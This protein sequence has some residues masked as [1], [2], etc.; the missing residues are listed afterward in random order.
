MDC[1]T[2]ERNRFYVTIDKYSFLRPL[3]DKERH[4]LN[5]ELFRVSL[6]SMSAAEA[7]LA[8]FMAAV[9]LGRNDFEFDLFEAM[10]DGSGIESVLVEWISD[11]Y[12]P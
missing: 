8:R 6:E 4:E 10:K 9:W 1:L 11:P 12:W 7:N 5:L 3:W 2:P